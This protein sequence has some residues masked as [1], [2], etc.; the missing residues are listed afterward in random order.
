M[1]LW[2][3]LLAVT[4]LGTTDRSAADDPAPPKP[5]ELVVP[6]AAGGFKPAAQPTCTLRGATPYPYRNVTVSDRGRKDEKTLYAYVFFPPGWRPDVGH[7]AIA[8]LHGKNGGPQDF[9]NQCLYFASRDMV[10]VSADNADDGDGRLIVQFLRANAD[11]LG[12]DPDAVACAGAAAG[13]T[14]AGIL[15]DPAGTA[16]SGKANTVACFHGSLKGGARPDVAPGIVF[17]GY[18]LQEQPERWVYGAALQF[19]QRMKLAGNRWR[20]VTY[21]EEP[22]DFYR[23]PMF[24]QEVNEQIEDFFAAAWDTCGL[25]LPLNSAAAA[26]SGFIGGLGRSAGQ[27]D[28]APKLPA[29]T[30]QAYGSFIRALPHHPLSWT[31]LQRLGRN[32]RIAS[33]LAGELKVYEDFVRAYGDGPNCTKAL[34]HLLSTYR[35]A[36]DP[37]ARVRQLGAAAKLSGR[38]LGDVL[39]PRDFD[40]ATGDKGRTILQEARLDPRSGREPKVVVMS[41]RTR[42]G[43][44][45][46]GY[47]SIHPR[48]LPVG[49]GVVWRHL[50]PTPRAGKWRTLAIPISAAGL[51]G[52][53]VLGIGFSALGGQVWWDRT[54]YAADGAETVLIDDEL[55]KGCTFAGPSAA[56]WVDYPVQSGKAAHTTVDVAGFSGPKVLSTYYGFSEYH[57]QSPQVLLDLRGGAPERAAPAYTLTQY[58][59]AIDAIAGREEV[60]RVLA[61]AARVAERQEPGSGA[62]LVRDF[63]S[64]RPKSP[65]AYRALLHLLSLETGGAVDTRFYNVVCKAAFPDTGRCLHLLLRRRGGQWVEQVKAWAAPFSR[66]RLRAVVRDRSAPADKVVVDVQTQ[67]G[68]QV[69]DGFNAHYT[70]S[71]AAPDQWAQGTFAGACDGQAVAG[72]IDGQ[73]RDFFTVDRDAGADS[74]VGRAVAAVEAFMAKASIDPAQRAAFYKAL[75]IKPGR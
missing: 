31:F 72:P 15:P 16:I 74:K 46:H 35:L 28:E 3:V 24:Q 62:R 63:L 59:A 61:E 30:Q 70:L 1:R 55:P 2:L 49:E 65:A 25:Y 43:W 54:V 27:D 37:P 48:P 6:G 71:L 69:P 5:E 26:E 58:R 38:T 36:D 22:F 32:A 56:G 34:S 68:R 39:E 9:W 42:E 47:W 21:E 14:L 12:V 66:G 20:L 60:G 11:K 51:D 33:R 67:R 19:V 29:E 13:A 7:R 23:S 73:C 40:K 45:N 75:G 10:A 18:H 64:R 57:V 52:K 44:R 17:I 8:F 41:F 50:G 53:E 4:V